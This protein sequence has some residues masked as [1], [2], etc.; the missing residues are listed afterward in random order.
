MLKESDESSK[1]KKIY[2]HINTDT[3]RTKKEKY[4]I[5]PCDE[6]MCF[7]EKEVQF[8]FNNLELFI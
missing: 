1:P 4:V 8:V 2:R 3:N 5:I 6:E 7:T